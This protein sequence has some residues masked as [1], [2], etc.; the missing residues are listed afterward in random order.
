LAQSLAAIDTYTEA[1]TKASVLKGANRLK[2]SWSA[3][4]VRNAD[5]KTQVLDGT[6]CR[7]EGAPP[8]TNQNRRR[9]VDYHDLRPSWAEREKHYGTDWNFIETCADTRLSSANTRWRGNHPVGAKTSTVSLCINRCAGANRPATRHYIHHVSRKCG[10]RACARVSRYRHGNGSRR[11]DR[12][13][14][15][16]P[17][18]DDTRWRYRSG[19]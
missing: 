11:E 13:R 17:V 15:K 3:T 10:G 1:L 19:D 4:T 7:F 2:P 9:R 18:A 6:L 8:A 16:R 12:K 5:G 14:P